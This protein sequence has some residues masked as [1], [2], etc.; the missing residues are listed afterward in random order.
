MAKRNNNQQESV[1]NIIYRAVEAGRISAERT[2]RDAFKATERRLYAL[3]DLREKLKEDEEELHDTKLYGLKER[4]H[5][6]TRFFK[7]GVRLTPEEILEAVIMDLEATIARDRHEKETLEKA[8][9]S[10]EG[11]PYYMAVQG[12]YIDRLTDEE[13]AEKIPCDP[14]TVWRNRKRLVQRIAVRLYGVE[15]VK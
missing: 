4:S 6:I 5:S 11:D 12:K 2:A 3:P 13:V 15:A 1:E 10:I 14:A 9:A 7:S 8:L